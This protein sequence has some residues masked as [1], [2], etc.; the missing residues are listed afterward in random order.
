VSTAMLPSADN[1]LEPAYGH[2]EL[3]FSKRIQ[4]EVWALLN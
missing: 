1:R 2:V 4:S 3:A